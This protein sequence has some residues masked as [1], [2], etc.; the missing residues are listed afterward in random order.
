MN[1]TS[2]SLGNIPYDPL[3]VEQMLRNYSYLN[4]GLTLSFNGK[5]F[6]S[7]ETACSISSTNISVARSNT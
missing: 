1:R 2:R 5:K 3:I 6:R 7:K 4:Q